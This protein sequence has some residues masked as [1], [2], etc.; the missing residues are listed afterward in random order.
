MTTSALNEDRQRIDRAMLLELA[1]SGPRD[2][3]GLTDQTADDGAAERILKDI[4]S[5]IEQIRAQTINSPSFVKN[6]PAD[7]SEEEISGY[8][9]NNC[10]KDID[11]KCSRRLLAR[12]I[13]LEKSFFGWSDD[14]KKVL[15][16]DEDRDV[17]LDSKAVAPFG[18]DEQGAPNTPFGVHPDNRPI[19]P[20]GTKAD[21][22]AKAPFGRD[23]NGLPIIR[24]GW[25][26]DLRRA[27]WRR[28]KGTGPDPEYEKHRNKV[29]PTARVE[30]TLNDR[31]KAKA[32]CRGVEYGQALEEAMENWI[33]REPE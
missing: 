22:S 32:D 30:R 13:Y 3:S 12:F 8:I 6:F 19:A 31:F 26:D 15:I 18:Y 23:E 10:V 11:I 20:F 7:G 17:K 2:R 4:S 5:H 33:S 24:Y 25:H 27:R 28:A 21:G 16:D 1:R 14:L 29:Q 9:Y